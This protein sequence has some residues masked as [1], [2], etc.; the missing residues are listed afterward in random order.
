ML[1]K[2][3]KPFCSSVVYKFKDPDT[4][5]DYEAGTYPELVQ[6]IVK[7][8]SQNNLEKI[9]ALSQVLD[10]YLCGLPE[11]VGSCT[12][13]LLKRSLLGYLKGGIALIQNMAYDTIATQ[14][15]A[16]KRS[17]ICKGC[18]HNVF[19]DKG[20]FIYWSDRIAEASIGNRKS[21]NHNDLGNCEIC[22]CPLRAKVFF[23][24]KID[25]PDK[26]HDQLPDFCWQR[27]AYSG[28]K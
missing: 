9:E 7:Y 15:V 3:F 22:S 28:N 26:E 27:R 2:K 16:D 10:N 5:Y 11:N 18:P 6:K 1:F 19:P 14:E 8:R 21:V 25:L 13:A 20:P 17:E 23:G 24:G 4:G 12:S